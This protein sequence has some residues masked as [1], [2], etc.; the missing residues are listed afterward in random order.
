MTYNKFCKPQGESV[1]RLLRG[2]KIKTNCPA[3]SAVS[4][5]ERFQFFNTDVLLTDLLASLNSKGLHPPYYPF[6]TTE[7]ISGRNS[8]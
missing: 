2:Q 6:I 1:K 3:R 8:L 5:S 7:G 4:L